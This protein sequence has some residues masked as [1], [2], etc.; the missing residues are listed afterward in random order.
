[1]ATS[2][3]SRPG[4][5]DEH[6]SEHPLLRTLARGALVEILWAVGLLVILGLVSVALSVAIGAVGKAQPFL[7]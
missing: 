5:H 1:M 4:S 3:L 2:G 7:T 6:H